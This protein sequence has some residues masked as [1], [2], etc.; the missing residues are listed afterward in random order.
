MP[1]FWEHIF[2]IRAIHSFTRQ[3]IQEKRGNYLNRSEVKEDGNFS[4][5]RLAMLDLLLSVQEENG[6]ISEDGIREEVDT[7]MFE[8]HDTT[9]VS[10]CFT[11]ML[12]AN[13]KNIQEKIYEEVMDVFGHACRKPTYQDLQNLKYL[14]LCIKECLRLYP[15]VPLISRIATVDIT[16]PSGYFIPK[17]VTFL[18]HL[19]DLHHNPDIYPNPEKFDPDRFLPENCVNRHPFAYLPFSGGPRNCIGRL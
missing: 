7:F 12:L 5:K 11:L 8:G 6:G 18:I 9:S 4:K 2:I 1:T 3:V 15:S 10:L 17:G 19:Y 14:E 13:N 16:L